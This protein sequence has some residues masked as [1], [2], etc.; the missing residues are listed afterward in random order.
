M[1]PWCLQVPD[2]LKFS[3]SKKIIST[4]YNFLHMFKI[5][6]FITWKIYSVMR[7]WWCSLISIPLEIGVLRS[8]AGKMLVQRSAFQAVEMLG[9]LY[10]VLYRYFA[11][12]R[13][14]GLKHQ[15]RSLIPVEIRLRNYTDGVSPDMN[16]TISTEFRL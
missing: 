7:L 1:H 3:C 2:I 8:Y 4:S 10:S 6:F 9:R 14:N 13:M 12:I 15:G 11:I 5:H 16:M